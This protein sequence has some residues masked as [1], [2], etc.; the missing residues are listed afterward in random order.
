MRRVEAHRDREVVVPIVQRRSRHAEDQVE[1]PV[2]ESR[3]DHL[4]CARHIIRVVIAFQ[5]RKRS[6]TE[7]LSPEADAR[8]SAVRQHVR[9]FLV[10]RS[11]I[12]LDRP[13]SSGRE[14]I[15]AAGCIEQTSKLR[16]IQS[17][18]SASA[19]PPSAT[20]QI[21]ELSKS[22]RPDGPRP[23]ATR[24][25]NSRICVRKTGCGCRPH[26]GEMST[27]KHGLE[28]SDLGDLGL[29]RF[30]DPHRECDRCG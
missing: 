18:R 11:R 28:E 10:E 23:R 22:G 15:P 17:R 30:L 2:R 5:S 26:A 16:S 8:D 4:Q 14:R 21:R 1:R 19:E 20:S 29:E 13:L 24:S 3:P 7:R 9:L 6:R 12:R 25:R 27:S